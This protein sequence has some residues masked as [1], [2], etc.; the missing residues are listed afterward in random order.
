MVFS[1]LC[2]WHCGSQMAS[3]N[4]S[5]LLGLP[6]L[7]TCVGG[8]WHTKTNHIPR[9]V[10]LIGKWVSVC[11]AKTQRENRKTVQRWH[12]AE[13][14]LFSRN[15]TKQKWRENLSSRS[16]EKCQ[17]K[18]M[19]T[20]SCWIH[21]QSWGGQLKHHIFIHFNLPS[22]RSVSFIIYLYVSISAP[23]CNNL[24]LSSTRGLGALP[25]GGTCP[26]GVC[27]SV[28]VPVLA[29]LPSRFLFL[30]FSLSTS[31]APHRV[32]FIWLGADTFNKHR[33]NSHQ[34]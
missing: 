27:L 33:P 19:C 9:P 3:L 17:G 11:L 18:E 32:S 31:S 4:K 26:A 12:H 24:S 22:A 8:G 20:V 25:A 15:N 14:T 6:S 28:T 10:E 1:L 5:A 30:R 29:P 23:N 34:H 21:V 16:R 2:L 7:Y 13:P